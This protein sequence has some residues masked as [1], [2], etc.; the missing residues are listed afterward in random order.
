M[1]V[2]S[3]PLEGAPTM[4][5]VGG[6][7]V[8]LTLNKTGVVPPWPSLAVMVT[9]WAGDSSAPACDQVQVPVEVPVL[10]SVPPDADRATL[11][12]SGSWYVPVIVAVEP[13]AAVTEVLFSVKSGARLVLVLPLT[14]HSWNVKSRPYETW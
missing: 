10:V 12:P 2:A 7:G 6:T 3:G 8:K 14:S 5:T 4:V 1:L 11:S 9:C 13:S